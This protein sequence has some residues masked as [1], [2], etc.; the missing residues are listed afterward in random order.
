MLQACSEDEANG[1]FGD[2]KQMLGL[3]EKEYLGAQ[4]NELQSCR[5]LAKGLDGAEYYQMKG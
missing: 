3:R 1:A 4:A 2:R 5:L